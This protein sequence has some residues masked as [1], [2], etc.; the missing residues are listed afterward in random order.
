MDSDH[1][2]V[3]VTIPVAEVQAFTATGWQQVAAAAVGGAILLVVRMGCVA[4]LVAAGVGLV[5]AV[6]GAAGKTFCAALGNFLGVFV[7]GWLVQYWDKTLGSA[8]AWAV[9]VVEALVAATPASLWEAGINT[10]AETTLAVWLTSFGNWMVNTAGPALAWLGTTI[11]NGIVAVG[12]FVRDFAAAIPGAVRNFSVPTSPSG[13]SCDIYTFY[14]TPCTAAYS[15]DR[16]LYSSY[17]G[18]LYQVQR[19]SDGTTADIGLLSVGGDVNA[20]EQG[21]FCAGTPCTVTK[22]YDQSPQW[23]DLTIEGGDQGASATALPI[24]IGGNNEAYGIDIRAGDGYRNNSTQGIAVKGQP[25]GM[26]M[27]T[28]GTNV[29]AGCCFDFGNVETNGGDNGAG[30]MDAVNF[31]TW[32]G[33]NSQPCTGSGPWVEADLENGQWM[34]GN[35]S[36]PANTGNSSDFVTALLKNDGQTTFALK[37]GNAQSG[38]LTTYWDGNLPGGYAMSQEGGI[39]LGTGGDNSKWSVGSFF[40]GVMTAGYPS[41]AADN[42]VQA[43]IV[44]AGYAGNSGSPGGSPGNGLQPPA[45]T[46]TMAGGN[47]VDVT[48]DDTGT[49]GTPVVSWGCQSTAVDQHWTRNANLSLETLGRCLSI[50]TAPGVAGTGTGVD[51]NR[52]LLWDCN[53]SGVEQWVQRPN[54]TLYNPPSGLCLYGQPANGYQLLVTSCNASDPDQQFSVNGGSTIAAPG[55]Q[56]VDVLGDNTGTDSAPVDLWNCQ[57][58][59]IDQHWTYNPATGEL[60]TLGRCLDVSGDSTASTA[61]IDLFDCADVGGQQWVPQSNGS[62]LNPQ[63][64]LCLD[65]PN[66]N[67]GNGTHL[68]IFTCTGAANQVFTLGE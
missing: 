39:V 44:S 27:V 43:S 49:N 4:A 5:G 56:C 29:N 18:P 16:A 67:T 46:I 66:G 6:L 58:S 38:G 55:G 11:V 17:N 9:T 35:G 32:C 15:M 59:A 25:E 54:G 8:T 21:S 20:A 47:C 37:G 50:S 2:G 41:D 12:A 28:S 40:E 52:T 3:S 23:N 14:G 34:G 13:L 30:H 51:G 63:S 53:G 24:T 33:S 60:E 62:L 64:G 10:F 65:D 19:A 22:L 1:T 45:G 42:A 68:Q 57:S 48:G 31:G 61:P 26:Y 7:R 36:N